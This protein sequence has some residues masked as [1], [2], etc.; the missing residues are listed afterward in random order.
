MELPRMITVGSFEAKTKLAELLAR[1]LCGEEVT[2][3][4]HRVPVA[5][6]VPCD[7]LVLL[8]LAPGSAQQQQTK[9]EPR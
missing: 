9:E 1:V 4:K 3:T 8:P 5:R 2:I 7:S 6:L